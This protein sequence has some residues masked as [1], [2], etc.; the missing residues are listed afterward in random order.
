[1]RFAARQQVEDGSD[2]GIRAE[3]KLQ[4]RLKGTAAQPLEHRAFGF[5]D[6]PR[7]QLEVHAVCL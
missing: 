7:V 1:V 2:L 3:R 5:L 4:D 6:V